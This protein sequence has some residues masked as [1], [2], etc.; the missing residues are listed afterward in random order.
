MAQA[1]GVLMYMHEMKMSDETNA[2]SQGKQP[3]P[4][5]LSSL[6]LIPGERQEPLSPCSYREGNHC[7]RRSHVPALHS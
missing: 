7:W 2:S 3:L 5:A 6:Q 4:T 1:P